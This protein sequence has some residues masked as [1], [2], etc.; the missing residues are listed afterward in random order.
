MTRK[1]P[2]PIDK[3]RNREPPAPHLMKWPALI[4][5]FGRLDAE[6]AVPDPKALRYKA[7]KEQ[8]QAWAAKY[9]PERPV[10]FQGNVYCV[11]VSEQPFKREITDMAKLAK[12]LGKK[13]LE[14]CSVPLKEIDKKLPPEMHSL[15]LSKKREGPRT[16]KVVERAAARKA[17]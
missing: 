9:A 3:R 11:E 16:L 8:I 4:D 1:K 7:L 15:V 13:F 12:L 6:L 17:A 10:L 2:H 14:V 5:E